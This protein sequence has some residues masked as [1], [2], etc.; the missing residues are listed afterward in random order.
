MGRSPGA[1]AQARS[2]T[3]AGAEVP[4]IAPLGVRI[5]KYLD[6]PASARGPAIDPARGYRLQDL[7]QGLYMITDNVVQSMFLVYGSGVVVVDAPPNYAMRIPQAIAEVTDN[8]ITQCDLQPFPHRSHRGHCGAGGTADHHR[9]GGDPPPAGRRIPT[10][11]SP[12]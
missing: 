7:G 4:S 9:S 6:V 10:G 2:S 12:T 3:G 8:R 5:D 1:H 11:R